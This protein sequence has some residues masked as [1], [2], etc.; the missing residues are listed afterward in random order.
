MA[1]P[2]KQSFEVEVLDNIDSVEELQ[3]ETKESEDNQSCNIE[4]EEFSDEELDALNIEDGFTSGELYYEVFDTEMTLGIVKDNS[5]ELMKFIQGNKEELDNWVS[6][7]KT[8]ITDSSQL[9]A[10][11]YPGAEHR[12]VSVLQ[13]QNQNGFAPEGPKYKSMMD[14]Y[15]D[16][17]ETSSEEEIA[18]AVFGNLRFSFVPIRL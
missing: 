2:R 5:E 8:E 7:L 14:F 17:H 3:L 13:Y 11:N 10:L 1:R 15:K 16:Q 4:I 6:E 9:L 12:Y 18:F